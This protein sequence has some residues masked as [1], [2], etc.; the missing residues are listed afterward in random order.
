MHTSV[1]RGLTLGVHSS[2]MGDRA[3]IEILG[4]YTIQ[5]DSAEMSFIKLGERSQPQLAACNVNVS[6][7]HPYIGFPLSLSCTLTPW[8][9]FQIN[10]LQQDFA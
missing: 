1:V 6:I 7:T 10:Y 3:D 9:H 4:S 2:S 5:K 8:D